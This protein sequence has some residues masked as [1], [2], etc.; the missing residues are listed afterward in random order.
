MA[1]EYFS[2]LNYTLANEDTKIEYDLLPENVDRVFCIAGSGARVLPLIAKNPKRLDVIDMSPTQLYLTELRHQAAQKM[3]YEEWLFFL[4]YRGGLQQSGNLAGDDR[5]ALYRR[6]KL[7]AEADAYWKSRQE[8]WAPR[9]FI[10]LGRWENHFQKLGRIFREA[11]RCDFDPI[12][13]AQSLAEQRELWEKHWP[14]LRFN[15][16]MRVAASETV[17]NRFL[18][19]GHFAGADG[20]RT[21]NRPPYQFLQEEFERLFHTVLVRKSFFMQVLFLGSVRY[22]EGLPLEAHQHLFE[23]L[24]TS[25]TEVTYRSANLLEVLGEAPWD[26]VSLSDT[27]SYLS[28]ED[29]NS[30]LGR[31]PKDT[32][33]GSVSVIRSFMRGPT[34]LKHHDWREEKALQDKAWREELTGVYRFHIHRKG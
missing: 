32:P 12:F 19:K 27:I 31:W 3:N 22:E 28:Q 14:K 10:L 21:E 23:K 17:F 24:Q 26:F 34:D 16:F 25:K 33:A 7:S 2:D 9:G 5:L 1:K 30:I 4:G 20:H 13:K 29:A 6:L 11:L 15:S 18:Y 8:C